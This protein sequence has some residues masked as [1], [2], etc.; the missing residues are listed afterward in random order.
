[1]AV[2]SGREPRIEHCLSFPVRCPL[3]GDAGPAVN[4]SAYDIAAGE[5]LGPNWSYVFTSTETAD[6]C[7]IHCQARFSGC[8][9]RKHTRMPRTGSS[10]AGAAKTLAPPRGQR[11]P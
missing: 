9:P 4:Y 6:A 7:L 2:R 5:P 10:I 3:N 11:E 8:R 1:M